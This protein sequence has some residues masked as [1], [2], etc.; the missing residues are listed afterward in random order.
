MQ[1]QWRI[2]F[3]IVNINIVM[4]AEARESLDYRMEQYC[5]L[6]RKICIDLLSLEMTNEIDNNIEQINRILDATFN[7]DDGS[8]IV[9]ND[10]DDGVTIQEYNENAEKE[11]ILSLCSPGDR[12][13]DPRS[14][15]YNEA[16]ERRIAPG[17]YTHTESKKDDSEYQCAPIEA[18]DPHHQDGEGS[19]EREV[20]RCL[21]V[22]G[23]DKEIPIDELE[24]LFGCYG[25]LEDCDVLHDLKTDERVGFVTYTELGAAYTARNALDD[26]T[27]GKRNI[28]VSYFVTNLAARASP[29][30][31][32]QGRQSRTMETERRRFGEEG[33]D[34]LLYTSEDSNPIRCHSL[35][36]AAFSP[37]L[38]NLLGSVYTC[39]GCIAYRSIVLVGENRETLEDLVVLL[40]SYR[41]ERV[42]PGKKMVELMVRLGINPRDVIDSQEGGESE[43]EVNVEDTK[44]T[45]FSTPF[46]Q[47]K[48]SMVRL[49]KQEELGDRSKLTKIAERP[50]NFRVRMMM[51]PVEVKRPFENM[52]VAE[53][54]EELRFRDL[55]T[56]G[57]KQTLVTRLNNYVW[58]EE[59]GI[60]AESY[61]IPRLETMQPFLNPYYSAEANTTTV[62]PQ[63]APSTEAILER[64]REFG[65]LTENAENN[66][67]VLEDAVDAPVEAK[68]EETRNED[69]TEDSNAS[70]M[71]IPSPALSPLLASIL[72][73]QDDGHGGT[74][75]E[76]LS[77]AT[78]GL[79]PDTSE[80]DDVRMEMMRAGE[81]DSS[82]DTEEKVDHIKVKK[83][84]IRK[85]REKRE[86]RRAIR[87]A[88][89]AATIHG[90][91]SKRRRSRSD[92]DGGGGLAPGVA[93]YEG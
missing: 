67:N 4:E 41:S 62:R 83:M 93:E 1:A 37:V 40:Y 26:T 3:N 77:E 82:S 28:R 43:E 63:F 16:S 91:A 14:K 49:T 31:V 61:K 50:E 2:E 45:M 42:A 25:T 68:Y 92:S 27:V 44:A 59:K 78:M 64:L 47:H 21:V 5:G 46:L 33:Q 15:K 73:V 22:S 12:V 8:D 71:S 60:K 19:T 7:Y 66:R 57:K 6:L 51:V 18:N 32:P 58:P 55:S 56:S 38:R 29:P 36:L 34:V 24:E 76:Q 87:D 35:V 54:K 17:Y 88:K 90:R 69:M 13:C 65:K 80:E 86:E 52:K 11:K 9:E 79:L 53:L 85:R 81:V 74:N 39:E 84:E 20:S 23:I 75:L 70:L 10:D 72:A 89:E 48:G 30:S